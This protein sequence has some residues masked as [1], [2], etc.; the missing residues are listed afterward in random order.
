MDWN[1]SNYSEWGNQTQRDNVTCFLFYVDNVAMKGG[2]LQGRR[3]SKWWYKGG[4]WRVIIKCFEYFY[5][6]EII[7]KKTSLTW[8]NI[9]QHSP[10]Q[11]S[12]IYFTIH[13]IFIFYMSVNWF[14][15]ISKIHEKHFF[16]LWKL[17]SVLLLKESFKE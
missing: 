1:G 17:I 10:Y 4:R 9:A 11:N 12:I 2:S 15:F 8:L 16:C 6:R 7:S 13:V 14:N 3:D 5:H